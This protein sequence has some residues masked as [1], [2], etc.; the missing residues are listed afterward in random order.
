MIGK[1]TYVDPSA[2]IIGRVTLKDG[3]SIWPYAVIR[4]DENYVIVGSGSNVQDHAVLH[5]T[6]DHPTIIGEDVTIGHGA[7]INGASIGDR[8]LIGMNCTI[9]EG[10]TIG[11]GCIIGA[12]AV[13][14]GKVDIPPYSLVV[15]IPGK[16]VRS[17]DI[18]LE[19]KSL[20]NARDYHHLRDE[21]LEG[22]H[23]R[24]TF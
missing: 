21:Y 22:K 5:V 23:N 16:I 11:K 9:I 20:E 15:G 24:F 2:I 14:T 17:N 12:G 13:V 10:A 18:S 8:T 1:G 4:G 19:T 3:V 7:I 6:S